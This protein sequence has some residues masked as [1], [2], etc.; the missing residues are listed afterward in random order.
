MIKME[1]YLL[2]L[3]SQLICVNISLKAVG[4]ASYTHDA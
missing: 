1:I 3:D 4:N 2:L